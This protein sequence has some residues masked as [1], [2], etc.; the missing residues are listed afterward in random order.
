MENLSLAELKARYRSQHDKEIN[1]DWVERNIYANLAMPILK[2]LLPTRVSAN[3]VTVSSLLIGLLGCLLIMIPRLSTALVGVVF[4]Q[5]C[6]ILDYVDGALARAKNQ[7]SEKGAYL[8]KL[9]SLILGTAILLSAGFA[10]YF[11]Y[12]KLIHI[13]L[14][15]TAGISFFL[16]RCFY[17]A[18]IIFKL[19]KTND[20]KNANNDLRA[21]SN[22]T[23]DRITNRIPS[24][25]KI[26]AKKSDFLWVPIYFIDLL[27]IAILTNRP[28]LFIWF[29]GIFYPIVT[30]VTY[31]TQSRR[32]QTK[33]N[34]SI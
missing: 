23:I 27:T 28:Y 5:L 21:A 33:I 17:D 6:Y 8:E 26:I 3:Q 11:R 12:Y 19:K 25:L 34:F 1:L 29:Y 24:F 15:F 32:D 2:I 14:G 30:M 9:F 10:C 13:L 20:S 31:V 7:T 22:V 18:Q 16:L 4:F